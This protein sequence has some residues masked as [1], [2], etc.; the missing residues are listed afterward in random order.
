MIYSRHTFWLRRKES[1]L[2]RSPCSLDSFVWLRS[3]W[4][5][6][7]KCSSRGQENERAVVPVKL[8]FK[9]AA[10]LNPWGGGHAR[11]GRLR[12]L[13][14]SLSSI[15]KKW[16]RFPFASTLSSLFSFFYRS[17]LRPVLGRV[18]KFIV[19][20]VIQEESSFSLGYYFRESWLFYEV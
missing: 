3:S 11:S 20:K 13:S 4:P 14:L 17:S 2:Y 6:R 1:E 16:L 7:L 10:G 18:S 19:F 5:Q 15:V 12:S 8:K 9:L